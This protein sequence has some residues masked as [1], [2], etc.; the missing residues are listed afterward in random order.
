[1]AKR[2]FEK[3]MLSSGFDARDVKLDPPSVLSQN[4]NLD[5]LHLESKSV[6]RSRSIFTSQQIN[7]SRRTQLFVKVQV[8]VQ[9]DVDVEPPFPPTKLPVWR[10]GADP[11]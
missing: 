4:W 6:F 2:Q 3:Q 5:S 9:N 8:C 7:I 1:M 11:P 10:C